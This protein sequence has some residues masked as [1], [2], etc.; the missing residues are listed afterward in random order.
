MLPAFSQDAAQPEGML[1]IP[2]PEEA[3]AASFSPQVRAAT[4]RTVRKI[5]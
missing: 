5:S 3:P 2:L 4:E 1:S